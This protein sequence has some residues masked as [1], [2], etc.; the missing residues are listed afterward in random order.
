MENQ[1][2]FTYYTGGPPPNWLDRDSWYAPVT[3]APAE[4]MP[5]VGLRKLEL[6]VDMCCMKCAEI[7]SEEIRELPGV[8]DVQ[9]D[10]KLKKV[11]VIGMPFEPDVLK[12]AKK[13]DKKAH[14]WP[15]PAPEPAPAPPPPP[16]P[17]P[18][19]VQ[20]NC[21]CKCK[22]E[23]P[24]KEEKKEDEKKEEIKEE[25]KEEEK[26]EEEKKEEKKEEEKK[27]E[28][29]EEPKKEEE[30][31]EEPKKEEKPAPPPPA[32]A[33]TPPEPQPRIFPPFEYNVGNFPMYDYHPSQ[34]YNPL[35]PYSPYPYAR[36]I[37]YDWP[38]FRTAEGAGAAFLPPPKPSAY[39][40]VGDFWNIF[41][42]P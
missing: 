23:D 17:A 20:C 31:K 18:I 8:L 40:T 41:Q 32:P 24:P 29:K 35:L 14:W 5:P 42:P 39:Q 16:P 11:T 26:K 21:T 33:P 25:K 38:H 19:I 15:P 10:Y 7:V 27:E 22:L 34:A 6:K 2:V 3:V 9:V 37:Y 1:E 13:V 36:P 4:T 12:R 30:K 28:K